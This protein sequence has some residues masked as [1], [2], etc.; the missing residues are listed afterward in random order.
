MLASLLKTLKKMKL[1]AFWKVRCDLQVCLP[2]QRASQECSV[3]WAEGEE[4]PL[5]P[6]ISLP[7]PV[8]SGLTL[9]QALHLN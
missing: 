9:S 5:T 1:T 7:V 8:D 6:A 2:A 4:V 3:W